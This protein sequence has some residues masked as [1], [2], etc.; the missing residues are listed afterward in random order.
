MF[1]DVC[2]QKKKK[3][4]LPYIMK[5]LKEVFCAT[6]EMHKLSSDVFRLMVGSS[7]YFIKLKHEVKLPK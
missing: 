3:K 1:F 2:L 4:N 7:D 5:P 6:K